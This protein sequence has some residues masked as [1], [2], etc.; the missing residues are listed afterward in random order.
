MRD[1]IKNLNY[2]VGLIARDMTAAHK[3]D[4]IKYQDYQINMTKTTEDNLQENGGVIKNQNNES[5]LENIAKVEFREKEDTHHITRVYLLG[6]FFFII[7]ASNSLTLQR[8]RYE[9]E[10]NNSNALK[11]AIMGETQSYMTINKIENLTLF[12]LEEGKGDWIQ[13][14]NFPCT[15][16]STVLEGTECIF[17]L[18]L[19]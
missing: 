11:L 3:A 5:N 12:G 9:T 1:E 10:V 18:N 6:I 4:W 7:L 16:E 8:M 14:M 15:F 13:N 2:V 19:T 17:M